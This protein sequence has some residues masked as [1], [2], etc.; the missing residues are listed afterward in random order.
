MITSIISAILAGV[1]S[2][3]VLLGLIQVR[4]ERQCRR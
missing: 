4:Q 3:G 2:L 1:K